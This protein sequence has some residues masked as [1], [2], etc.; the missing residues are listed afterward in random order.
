MPVELLLGLRHQRCRGDAGENDHF[1]CKNVIIHSISLTFLP[2]LTRSPYL[3]TNFD[4][5]EAMG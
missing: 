2:S 4:V 1:D 5:R 3:Q